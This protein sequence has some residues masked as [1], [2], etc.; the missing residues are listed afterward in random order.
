MRSDIGDIVPDNL[1]QVV[2]DQLDP[3]LS[4]GVLQELLQLQV[5]FAFWH[6]THWLLQQTISRCEN[7]LGCR[8]SHP[9]PLVSF[10]YVNFLCCGRAEGSSWS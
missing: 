4:P 7:S 10:S 6:M 5:R 2:F 1:L 8:A 3:G 9:Q